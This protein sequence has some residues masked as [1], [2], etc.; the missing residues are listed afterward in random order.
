[1]KPGLGSGH[2]ITLRARAPFF[3]TRGDSEC[4]RVFITIK[5]LLVCQFLPMLFLPSCFCFR[6]SMK[7]KETLSFAP[8]KRHVVRSFSSSPEGPHAQNVG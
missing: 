7:G 8:L 2:L 6:S 4:I 1:M 3:R 5:I